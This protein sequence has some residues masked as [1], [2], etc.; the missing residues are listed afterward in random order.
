MATRR[1]FLTTLA[2]GSV[3]LG[4]KS[5]LWAGAEGSPV[6]VRSAKGGPWSAATTW[7]GG[8][9]PSAGAVVEILPGHRVIYDVE[10][11]RALRMVHVQGTLAFARSRN[12]RLDVGLLKIGGDATEDGAN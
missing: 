11:N 10:S 5:M 12:T 1:D 4:A 3:A 8:V 6:R 7:E 2:V 9:L